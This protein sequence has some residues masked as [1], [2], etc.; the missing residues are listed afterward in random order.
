[1]T[2]NE[3]V[4]ARVHLVSERARYSVEEMSVVCPCPTVWSRVTD[5]GQL[6]RRDHSYSSMR[7][8][9]DLDPISLREGV[10]KMVRSCGPCPFHS[11]REFGSR[12]RYPSLAQRP[13]NVVVR[14]ALPLGQR[15]PTFLSLPP[16]AVLVFMYFRCR[17]TP[18]RP[19]EFSFRGLFVGERVVGRGL[20]T[21]PGDG[22]RYG[23]AR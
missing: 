20:A 8:W 3:I 17:T 12:Q 13:D 1:M 7:A 16:L 11:S 22:H 4:G 19:H 18:C 14:F 5:H 23:D 15:L 6:A 21:A 10:Q 2:F 9:Q